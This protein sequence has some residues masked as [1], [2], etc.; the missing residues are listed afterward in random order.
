MWCRRRT[1]GL[2]ARGNDVRFVALKRERERVG[3]A[4]TTRSWGKL[5]QPRSRP[6]VRDGENQK[7]TFEV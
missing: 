1:G 5:S 7:S 6:F 4:M 3:F 2:G